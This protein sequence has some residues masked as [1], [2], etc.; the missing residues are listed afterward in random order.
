MDRNKKYMCVSGVSLTCNGYYAASKHIRVLCENGKLTLKGEK[1]GR[2]AYYAYAE[3]KERMQ[4]SCT[5]T[6]FLVQK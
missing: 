6:R 1:E 4:A 2:I 3:H 5:R